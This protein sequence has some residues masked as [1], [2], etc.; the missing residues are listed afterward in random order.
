MNCLICGKEVKKGKN[1]KNYCCKSCYRKHYYRQH[2]ADR[3]K[4]KEK[5]QT[6]LPVNPEETRICRYCG[7]QNSYIYCCKLHELYYKAYLEIENGKIILKER[8]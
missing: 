2:K 3:K 8:C 6:D 5:Q 1:Y 4:P 7:K